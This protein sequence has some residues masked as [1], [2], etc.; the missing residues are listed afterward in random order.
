MSERT[1]ACARCREDKAITEFRPVKQRGGKPHVW[2]R[3]CLNQYRADRLRAARGLPPGTPLRRGADPKPIGHSYIHKGYRIIKQPDHHRADKYGYVG[4]HVLVAEAKYGIKVGR[5]FT[6]HH[7]NANRSDNR[8]ENLELRVGLHGKGGDVLHVLLN[9]EA[10][11]VE[12]AD[13]LRAHGW[14]VSR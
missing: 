1:K 14:T 6:V 7:R 4:E 11:R 5:E 2:C 10:A 9:N 13:I 3:P 8:P 12:A